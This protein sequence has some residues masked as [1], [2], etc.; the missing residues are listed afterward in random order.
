MKSLF[1]HNF[2][3]RATD[4]ILA[5]SLLFYF[6]FAF[7]LILLITLFFLPFPPVYLDKRMGQDN[8]SF[9]HIK[10]KSMKPGFHWGKAFLEADRIPPWGRL[11][12]R[13][14]FDELPELIHIL[15]GQMSFVGP[16]PL[17][18]LALENV[19]PVQRH[20]VKPGWTG[21]AQISLARNGVLNKDFQMRLDNLY[22]KK[23]SAAYNAQIFAATIKAV[24]GSRKHHIDQ[25][26]NN[27]LV[28]AYKEKI[29]DRH[30]H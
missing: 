9:L 14:H 19:R 25:T 8:K 7:L 16:R 12:R 2:C 24:L 3:I 21:L 18:A 29:L 17:T 26:L 23:R 6:G 27:K 15:T 1:F 22:L 11:M 4:V 10:I 30:G 13:L 20:A 28:D 5:F